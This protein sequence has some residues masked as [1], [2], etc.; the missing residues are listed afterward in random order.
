MKD[1]ML[2]DSGLP[3]DFLAKIIV[4]TNYLQNMLST[5][6]KS[7]EKLIFEET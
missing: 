1:A 5:R 4:T 7:Y 2:I 3:N 6:N